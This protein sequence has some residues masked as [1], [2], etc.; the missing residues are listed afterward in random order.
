M[1]TI[2]TDDAYHPRP[3]SWPGRLLVWLAVISLVPAFSLVP[4]K[5]F[6]P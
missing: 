6:G 3:F 2:C 5:V 1:A 4:L